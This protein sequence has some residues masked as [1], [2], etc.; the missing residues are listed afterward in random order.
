MTQW[1]STENRLNSSGK[2]SQDF[3]PLSLVREIQN[4]LETK[5]IRPEDFKD[6][7]HL[8][9]S[10]FNDI[11]WKKNDE[12]CISNA[13]E[14]RIYAMKFLQG[15]WTILGPGS[16]PKWY[17]D[18]HDQKGQW[19]CTANKMVQRFKETGHPVFKSTSA[20]SR[21]FLM[22]RKG[23]CTIHFNGDIM[24]TELLFHTVHSI[25]S[26]QCLRSSCELVLSIR[27]DRR[28][29][30]TSRYSCMQGGAFLRM[31]KLFALI[32]DMEGIWQCQFPNW[33][34]GCFDMMTKMND[35]VMVRDIGT[36]HKKELETF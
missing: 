11:V 13:E 5:N 7:I 12:N 17:G 18:S 26:A 3:R 15:H 20:L 4:D 25:P 10:M 36:L 33:S 14:D 29:K 23:K 28:G 34:L 22:Q 27:L 6:R 8:H 35:N 31:R 1:D 9:V 2:S 16:E 32:H 30:R 19:N 24:I 21:G